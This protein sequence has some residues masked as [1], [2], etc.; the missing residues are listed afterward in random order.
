MNTILDEAE[1]VTNNKKF[2]ASTS[3][4]AEDN[5]RNMLKGQ[6]QK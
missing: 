6:H 3:P 2:G 5:R 4:M 1:T